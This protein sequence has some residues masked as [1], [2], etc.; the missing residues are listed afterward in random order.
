MSNDNIN[1]LLNHPAVIAI[2]ALVALVLVTAAF[3]LGMYSLRYL[4]KRG[5]PTQIEQANLGEGLKLAGA[6]IERT[7]RIEQG[8]V[9]MQEKLSEA[10]LNTSKAIS[11]VADAQ[12]KILSLEERSQTTQ[13]NLLEN[14]NTHEKAAQSRSAQ[15]EKALMDLSK[16]TEELVKA[17]GAQSSQMN[18]IA[19]IP[20]KVLQVIA[21]AETPEEIQALSEKLRSY[22]DLTSD[23]ANKTTKPL[24]MSEAVQ[25]KFDQEAKGK[26]DEA[27]IK[28]VVGNPT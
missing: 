11:V 21:A 23:I 13:E 9:S 15:I 3:A 4:F 8:M 2:L 22:S 14:L 24:V 6:A 12:S 5:T 7:D 16:F 28:E 18:A 17:V 20:M 1:T 25:A 27:S 26:T 19:E 10:L